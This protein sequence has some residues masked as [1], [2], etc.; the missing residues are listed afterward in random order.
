MAFIER[1]SNSKHL[2]L[3]TQRLKRNMIDSKINAVNCSCF[4][5]EKVLQVWESLDFPSK[6]LLELKV[7]PSFENGSVWWLEIISNKSSKSPCVIQ[8]DDE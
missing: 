3:S 2:R 7:S 4:N 5:P 6:N 1:L 8:R